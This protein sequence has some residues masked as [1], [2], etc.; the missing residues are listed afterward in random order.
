MNDLLEL[1][2]SPCPCGSPYQAVD[3]IH[4]RIDDVFEFDT[5]Q[6]RVTVTPDVL[7]NAVVDSDARIRDYRI[8]QKKDGQVTI[9]LDEAL[10]DEV[11]A[12]VRSAVEQ[13]LARLGAVPVV[14]TVRGVTPRFDRKLRRV[15]RERG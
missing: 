14:A 9:E 2:G 8:L 3:R 12:A 6:G 1:S 15:E 4:G 11:H 13:A 5:P 10:P 7:R